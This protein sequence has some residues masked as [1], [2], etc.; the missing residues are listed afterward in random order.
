MI[1][2]FITEFGLPN[3]PHFGVNAN[4]FFTNGMMLLTAI[5]SFGYAIRN[6]A[7][8]K[9]TANENNIDD[10]LQMFQYSCYHHQCKFAMH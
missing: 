3:I 10:I 6:N 5:N 9:I 8:M 4:V 1:V 2:L 7:I